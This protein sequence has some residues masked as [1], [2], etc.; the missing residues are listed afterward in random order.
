MNPNQR[1]NNDESE[2]MALEI[3]NRGGARM[4]NYDPSVKFY[5]E[6][7]Y[8]EHGFDSQGYD[9][10]GIHSS[11]YDPSVHFYNDS[12]YDP[13]MNF[14]DEHNYDSKNPYSQFTPSNDFQ[15]DFSIAVSNDQSGSTK[16]EVNPILINLFNPLFGAMFGTTD[17]L[18]AG[19]NN[20]V[21][22]G[23]VGGASASNLTTYFN[24]AGA[25]VFGMV[26][27]TSRAA[28]GLTIATIQPSTCS[29]LQFLL[30]LRTTPLRATLIRYSVTNA[31]QFNNAISIQKRTLFGGNIS[32]TV[33]TSGNKT[34]YQNQVLITDIP[35][36]EIVDQQ[37][38]W[39]WQVNASE[40]AETFSVWFSDAKKVASGQVAFK[41]GKLA[42][43][44]QMP[45]RPPMGGRRPMG[46]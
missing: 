32:N 42:P 18:L 7:G 38:G 12:S 29:M 40:T 39:Y 26:N 6:R 19:F 13:I 22:T 21:S 20:G 1:R 41:G 23:V 16:T 17:P 45:S 4:H 44:K 14:Y 36:K 35:I 10:S 43:R 11:Q 37:T 33:T 27:T 24:S 2:E 25:L 5:D 9:E 34:P 3:I 31:A 28:N 8:D 46:R 30:A 15:V